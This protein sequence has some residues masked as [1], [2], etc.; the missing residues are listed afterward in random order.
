MKTA[1]DTAIG[2]SVRAAV[3]V[4]NGECAGKIFAVWGSGG[5]CRCSV[6]IWAGPLAE[7]GGTTTAGGYG[8]DKYGSCL[9][10]IFEGYKELLDD[11]YNN[12]RSKMTL[13]RILD[14]GSYDRAFEAAGYQYFQVA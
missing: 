3:L 6:G 12:D 9:A 8:Y 7:F 13:S 11:P 2:K 14:G 1:Y 4:F 5:Q 10:H